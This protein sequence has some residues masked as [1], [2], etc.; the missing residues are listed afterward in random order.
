MAVSGTKV[1]VYV[2]CPYYRRESRKG[3]I[4]IGC[5]GLLDSTSLIR[6]NFATKAERTKYRQRFC[7][8][9]YT[10]C[11]IAKALD[12]KYEA[13]GIELLPYKRRKQ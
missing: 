6:N 4:W 5:E 2:E 1:S 8:G 7:N 9:D 11:L 3:E 13:E 12:E 10:K